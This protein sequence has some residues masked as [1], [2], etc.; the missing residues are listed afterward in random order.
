MKIN[1]HELLLLSKIVE[2]FAEMYFDDIDLKLVVHR[3]FALT[4]NGRIFLP[5]HNS[6]E[7]IRFGHLQLFRKLDGKVIDLTAPAF[8]W[9]KKDEEYGFVA[10]EQIQQG[11]YIEHIYFDFDGERSERIISALDVLYPDGMFHPRDPEA[12][13]DSFFRILRLY[14][15][16]PK[17]KLPEIG[18]QIE[19][20]M[21]LAYD[22][23]KTELSERRDSYGL[24]DIAEKLR[25]EPFQ[26]YDFHKTAE[27]LNLS[28]D[29]FRRL[30]RERHQ[31]P[32]HEYLSHQ[33][34]I[35]A[36]ELLEK[37]DMTIK[38]IVLTCNFKSSIDFSRRFKKYS[39]LS[40]RA[41]RRGKLNLVK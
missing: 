19:K 30:F 7:F 21:F 15:I 8:F 1:F 14:R 22:S 39:G 4:G 36:A 41:Y 37:T 23:S 6:L 18:M 24:E 29:H 33:R 9:M 26:D 2:T 38:E 40:P 10:D 34:M 20:L 3:F 27:E 5:E 13:I 35:R 12:V 11:K 28:M 25:S 31:L 32:P 17:G 16:D